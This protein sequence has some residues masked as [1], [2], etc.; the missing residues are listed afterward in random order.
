MFFVFRPKMR[1]LNLHSGMKILYNVGESVGLHHFKL[2]VLL[3]QEL[4]RSYI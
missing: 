3:G 4:L 2:M 1:A